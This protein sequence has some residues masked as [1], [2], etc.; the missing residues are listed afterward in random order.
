MT[1]LYGILG[2]LPLLVHLINVVNSKKTYTDYVNYINLNEK[3]KDLVFVG[4]EDEITE[5]KN[6]KKKEDSD[7]AKYKEVDYVYEFTRYYYFIYLL[8]GLITI[9]SPIIVLMLIFSFFVSK[10]INY[11]KYTFSSLMVWSFKHTI[12]L[13]MLFVVIVNSV[14]IKFN[15]L[16]YAISLITSLIN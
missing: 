11:D 4:T 6:E 9:N 7:Y 1:T 2:L 14:Q 3:F 10:G 12:L 8:I 15:F 13:S 16:N 5:A